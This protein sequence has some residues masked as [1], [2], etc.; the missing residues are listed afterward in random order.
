M[1]WTAFFKA[2]RRGEFKIGPLSWATL[3]CALL[4]AVSPV[5]FMPEALL[6]P[7]GLADDAGYLV[8][9][10]TTLMREKSRFDAEIAHRAAAE[11]DIIDVPQH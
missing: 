1:G 8:V 4:L 7:L 11:A 3:I 9:A 10:F 5:D 6:G 2:V